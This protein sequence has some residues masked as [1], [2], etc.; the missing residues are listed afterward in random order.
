M[1]LFRQDPVV[2]KLHE[3][4]EEIS[5]SDTLEQELERI[6]LGFFRNSEIL[7][8]VAYG[9]YAQKKYPNNTVFRLNYFDSLML[10]GFFFDAQYY[11][12]ELFFSKNIKTVLIVERLVELYL[13]QAEY[14]KVIDLCQNNLNIVLKSEKALRLYLDMLKRIS[15][16]DLYK[17]IVKNF[18]ERVCKILKSDVVPLDYV[19][20]KISFID[21]YNEGLNNTKD[22]LNNI[23]DKIWRLFHI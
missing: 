5:N 23:V 4:Y 21:L 13:Q 20:E 3:Y 17:F 16:F 11:I 9:Y 7:K 8:A 6:I 15:R 22:N 14:L 12:E 10:M 2:K 19:D 1:K 18:Y